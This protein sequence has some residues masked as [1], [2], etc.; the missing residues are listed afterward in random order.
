M[1]FAVIG[2]LAPLPRLGSSDDRPSGQRF[3]SSLVGKGSVTIVRACDVR[4]FCEPAK[5]SF[6]GLCL[7]LFLE[8]MCFQASNDESAANIDIDHPATTNSLHAF[9]Q[10]ASLLT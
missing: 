4:F 10:V 2:D 3:P 8:T 5:P 6:S 7:H 9:C 1:L